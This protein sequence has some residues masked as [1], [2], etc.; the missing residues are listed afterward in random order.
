M[1]F[2]YT[3]SGRVH[4]ERTYV[5]ID[6]IPPCRIETRLTDSVLIVDTHIMIDNAQ[7]LV[8]ADCEEQIDDLETLRNSV[9]STVRGI[10]DSFG[11]VEGRGYDLELTSVIAST[12]ER[13][14]VFG[15]EIG[16]L[17][18][19]MDKRPVSF[20]ELFSLLTSPT[21]P[22]DEHASFARM[23]L[24]IALGD[25]REAIR[26]PNLT[27]FFCFRAIECLRQCYLH[28]SKPDDGT[29]RKASWQRMGDELCID[30]SWIAD[31]Q[32]AS[33]SERHG[34]LKAM[35]GKQ[36]VDLML[37]TWKVVD[38]FILSAKTNFQP[39]SADIL[40]IPASAEHHSS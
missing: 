12:G 22:Q 39:L 36:R 17:Q 10:V 11:Y 16:A 30:K 25:L 18:A 2:T 19:E 3:F 33:V 9:E 27:A 7:I 20:G 37:R 1:T 14:A 26:S 35:S 21:Q 15:V 28:P 40:S 34:L 5:T 31:L 4:P 29:A 8:T 38:R 32:D 23:Q 24:R 13:W 6:G